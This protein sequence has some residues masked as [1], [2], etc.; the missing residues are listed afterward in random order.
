MHNDHMQTSTAPPEA[1]GPGID[2]P[3]GRVIFGH[4]YR[5]PTRIE[6]R[7]DPELRDRE[8]AEAARNARC[9]HCAGIPEDVLRAVSAALRTA[10]EDG[11]RGR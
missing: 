5:Q 3:D 7:L 2:H 4:D 10:R 9:G 6:P 11:R 1:A 8:R